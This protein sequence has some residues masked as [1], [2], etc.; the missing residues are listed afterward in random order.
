MFTKLHNLAAI[1]E[2]GC[3]LIVRLD[4]PEEAYRVAHAAVQGGVRALEITLSVPRALEI[5]RRLADDLRGQDVVVGAGTVLD[6]HAAYAAVAAGA[7]LLVSPQLNTEMLTVANRYQ[8]V[9]ISGAYTPTEIVDSVAAGA[10][11]VKLF[12]AEQLG[13]EYVRT[14]LAPLAHIPIAPTGGVTPDNV[15]DWFDVGV[16]AVGVGSYITKAAGDTGDYALVT[17]AAASFLD[18]VRAARS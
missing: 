2:T 8:A 10:D 11:I 7:H 15:A 9:S 6:G 13:P 17:K 14:V 1:D 4:D 16:A 18:A 3:V 12:P 5:I